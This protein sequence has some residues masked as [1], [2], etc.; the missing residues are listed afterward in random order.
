[1]D[2]YIFSYSES[3]VLSLCKEIEYIKN[4][5]NSINNSLVNCQNKI[6]SKRLISELNKLNKNREKITNISEFM[7]KEKIQGLSFE[8]L[9]ELTKRS[10][11]FQQI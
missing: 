11:S 10:N 6:L 3:L 8:F 1:M 5:S 9:L 4:R 7:F 2:K